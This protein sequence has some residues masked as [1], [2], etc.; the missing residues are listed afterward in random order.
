M[1][2]K[3]VTT[4]DINPPSRVRLP[5]S[6]ASEMT[7]HPLATPVEEQPYKVGNKRPPKHSQF[8]VG[9]SGNPKGRPKRRK[10][11]NTIIKDEM[12]RLVEV[13]TAKG[14]T[15]VTRAHAL[16]M[17]AIES[18][19]KGDLKA[20]E[21]LLLWFDKALPARVS[22]TEEDMEALAGADPAIGATSNAI[23]DWF[24]AE[25][26]SEGSAPDEPG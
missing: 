1:P 25:I 15:K 21:K 16:V 6:A 23:L 24:A 19:S 2:F 5:A 12:L 3:R 13:R 17:K 8:K 10:S 4:R 14:V 22:E 26:R 20:I 18:G 7:P 9:Q 11:F